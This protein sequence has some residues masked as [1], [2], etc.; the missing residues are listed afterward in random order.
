[1]NIVDQILHEVEA[2]GSRIAIDENKLKIIR[3]KLLNTDTINLINS[4]KAE[5]MEVL[6]RDQKARNEG[7]I[8]LI[9]GQVYER[10]YSKTSHVFI[11]LD[12]NYWT[13]CKATWLKGKTQSV[14]HRVIVEYANFDLA[15]LK[16]TQYINF[17]TEGQK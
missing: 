16:A 1:M 13:A 4:N 9:S 10:Q 8:P 17:V 3:G 5:I 15:L 12:S 6:A 2:C 11:M 7:F 14:S